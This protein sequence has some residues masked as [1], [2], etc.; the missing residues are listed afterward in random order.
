MNALD[1]TIGIIGGGNM[2]EVFAGALIQSD[3]FKPSHISVS[4]V[5]TDRLL[6]LKSKYGVNTTTNNSELF[7]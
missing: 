3:L 2:G 1:R 5:R 6:E 4:D 7:I